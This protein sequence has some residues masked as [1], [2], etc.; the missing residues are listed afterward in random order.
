MGG[1]LSPPGWIGDPA[2]DGESPGASREGGS[3]TASQLHP[4]PQPAL[5]PDRIP[6]RVP[7]A[8]QTASYTSS[9][10]ESHPKSYPTPHPKLHP[11]PH[12]KTNR[13]PNLVAHCF[14]NRIP[15]FPLK[16]RPKVHPTPQPKRG[17]EHPGA[18]VSLS[19]PT[20]WSIPGADGA[21][22]PH[23]PS[24][25]S[26]SSQ[27]PSV[28]HP[29]P[30]ALCSSTSQPLT[31]TSGN[32]QRTGNSLSKQI[33]GRSQLY[34]R[35]LGPLE[36]P[37][38]PSPPLQVLL[39][40]RPSPGLWEMN[41]L[42]ADRDPGTARALVSTAGFG[43]SRESPTIN[44]FIYSEE[45]VL[46]NP[47]FTLQ[48]CHKNPTQR[49]GVRAVEAEILEIQTKFSPLSIPNSCIPPQKVFPGASPQLVW[50][51]SRQMLQREHP[52][53]HPAAFGAAHSSRWR[54]RFHLGLIKTSGLRRGQG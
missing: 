17:V 22:H 6:H 12:P 7:V 24:A 14:P 44:S 28:S 27:T 52:D 47:Q 16:L 5:R 21:S 20:G 26:A 34:P 11:A 50:P 13:T 35:A 33:G 37:S 1:L 31:N 30:A 9:Q 25:D 46:L 8:S 32:T 51:L 40:R 23:P 29:K 48:G 43:R 3:R 36:N 19:I 2:G 42:V 10:A 54:F 38:A 39:E 53:L 4:N 49:D 45:T 15:K 41:Y 18:R